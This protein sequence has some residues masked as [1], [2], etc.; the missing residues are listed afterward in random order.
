MALNGNTG[1]LYGITFAAVSTTTGALATD[2]WFKIAAKSTASSGFPANTEAEDVFYNSTGMA[3]SQATGDSS[4][5]ATL[6]KLAFVT[7]ITDSE[8]KEKFEQTVQT[9]EVK[10]YQVGS[11]PEVTGSVSGYAF[12]NDTFQRDLLKKFRI[13]MIETSTGGVTRTEP[14]STVFHTLLSL[15]ESNDSDDT[16]RIYSYKPMIIDSLNIDK[17][18]E[19]PIPFTFNYTE[20]GAEKPNT[21]YVLRSTT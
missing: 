15:D 10:S 18:M 11:K 5:K 3:V 1:Y 19:G 6:T 13:V 2:S 17:P 21:W 16:Y 20:D 12:N 7:D 14:D 9:D 8:A 4:Q